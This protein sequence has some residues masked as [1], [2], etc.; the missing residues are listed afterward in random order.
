[1]IGF[2]ETVQNAVFIGWVAGHG[3]V[4]KGYGS[5]LW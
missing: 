2:M 3:L 4:G 5:K 1:M